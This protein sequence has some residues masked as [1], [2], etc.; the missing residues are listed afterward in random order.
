VRTR[1]GRIVVRDSGC[2][3]DGLI[4][5][6]VFKAGRD[7]L[8]PGHVY[9]LRVWDE[10]I[11]DGD[12]VQLVDMGESC[13]PRD[14]TVCGPGHNRMCCW[15]NSADGVLAGSHGGYLVLTREEFAEVS[16]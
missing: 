4:L 14:M 7:K 11:D 1:I 2:P 3:T 13:I 16:R 15:G 6:A 10:S 12:D 5:G 9:E 8:K